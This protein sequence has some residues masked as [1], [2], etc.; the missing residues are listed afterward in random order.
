[1]LKLEVRAIYLSHLTLAGFD[2]NQWIIRIFDTRF[3]SWEFE[4]LHEMQKAMLA[5][6]VRILHLSTLVPQPAVTLHKSSA[7]TS[8][9]KVVVNQKN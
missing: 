6:P 4:F 9:S 2:T 7:N 8:E 3:L 1:M 5:D